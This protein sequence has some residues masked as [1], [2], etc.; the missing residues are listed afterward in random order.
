[1]VN[2]GAKVAAWITVQVLLPQAAVDWTGSWRRELCLEV[3]DHLL[4]A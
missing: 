4:G 1:M 3:W 2:L